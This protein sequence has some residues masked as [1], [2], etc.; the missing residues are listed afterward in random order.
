MWKIYDALI[1]GIPEHLTVEYQLTGGFRCLIRAENTGISTL[2]RN[3]HEDGINDG[4]TADTSDSLCGLPLKEAAKLAKSWDFEK[5]SLGMAAINAYY[6]DYAL[7]SKMGLQMWEPDAHRVGDVFEMYRDKIAG[8]KVAMVGHFEYAAVWMKEAC[9]L[10]IF[11]REPWEGDL[12]DSAEEFYLP[13]QEYVFITGMAFTNKT[14]PRLLA[15]SQNATVILVGP[16]VPVTPI[17]FRF[18]VSCISSVCVRDHELSV[19][20]VRNG[21]CRD[22]YQSGSKLIYTAD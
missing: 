11:E 9:D 1:E 5:A 18:G 10:T 3:Y 12:P 14:L 19:E 6:N 2:V 17:L 4:K 8:K 16:T 21:A 13:E 7:L 20:N 15:L 22:I